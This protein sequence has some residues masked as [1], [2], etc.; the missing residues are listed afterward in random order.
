[1]IVAGAA[2]LVLGG[3]A[4]GYVLY[5]KHQSRDVHGSSTVEFIT[6]EKPKP[7]PPPPPQILWPMYG[8]DPARLRAPEGF[9]LRPPFR[10]VWRF[11]GRALLEFPPVLG[12][13]HLYF[14]NN[15]GTLYALTTRHGRIGWRFHSRRCAAASQALYRGLVIAV[16]LNKP[17]CNSTRS[18]IDGLIAAFDVRTGKIRWRHVIGPSETSPVISDGVVYVGDWRNNVYAFTATTGRLHW[19]YSTGDK[20][21]GGPAISGNRLYVGSY[22]GYLYALD[23][24]TGRLIWRSASQQRLG[25]KGTFY[26]GPAVAYGRVYIGST[27][28]KVYSYGARSGKLRWSHGTGSYVYASPAVWRGLILIGSYDGTFYAFDAATGDVRWKFHARRGISGSAVVIN[29]V[30]YFSSLRGRTYALNPANGRVVW[31]F[32]DGQYAAAIAG[33]QRLYLVGY[34]RLY[35]LIPQSYGA[36]PPNR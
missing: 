18:D 26:S 17:P 2:L 19:K 3:L 35:A 25:G 7:E 21:K 27:D 30:V 29:G 15:S 5:R 8:Y 32:A 22:D 14:T 20:I 10:P 33:R 36:G 4:G 1:M 6:T 11:P 28:G 23:K 12:Y 31:T 9:K 24:R 13:G 34:S 16:F